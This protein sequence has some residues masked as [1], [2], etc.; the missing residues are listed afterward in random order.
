M[1]APYVDFPIPGLSAYTGRPQLAARTGGS[2]ANLD[3]S[4][5]QSS[6]TV[7]DVDTD[8]G[9]PIDPF[10]ATRMAT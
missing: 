6:Y 9:Y 4:G 8:V 3:V 7:G 2:G 10:P 1:I 5:I